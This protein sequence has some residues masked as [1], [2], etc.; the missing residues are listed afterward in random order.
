MIVMTNRRVVIEVRQ[1]T[2]LCDREK[3]RDRYDELKSGY[4]GQTKHFVSVMTSRRVVIE[5]RQNTLLCDREKPRDRYDK[6][7]SGYRGKTKHPTE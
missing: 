6:L 3:P 4:R 1:N 2:L 5:V 7:K